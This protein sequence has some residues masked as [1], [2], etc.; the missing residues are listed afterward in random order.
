MLKPEGTE[1]ISGNINLEKWTGKG[2]VL[3]HTRV[4]KM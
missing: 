4:N 2:G 1:S 3:N